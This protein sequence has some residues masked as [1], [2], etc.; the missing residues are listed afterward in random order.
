MVWIYHRYL[1]AG[2]T[3]IMLIW[4]NEKLE[5]RWRDGHWRILFIFSGNEYIRLSG[6]DMII[7]NMMRAEG[8]WK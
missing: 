7:R 6:V 1:W 4:E 3:A 5:I 8:L 2:I